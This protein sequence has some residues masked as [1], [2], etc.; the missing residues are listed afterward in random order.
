M[1]GPYRRFF[2]A[3]GTLRWQDFYHMGRPALRCRPTAVSGEL[4]CRPRRGG[5][6]L[7]PGCWQG[8]RLPRAGV[9]VLRT[10]AAFAR[11]FRCKE[12]PDLDWQHARLVLVQQRLASA[13]KLDVVVLLRRGATDLVA[14]IETRCSGVRQLDRGPAVDRRLLVALPRDSGKLSVRIERAPARCGQV[15]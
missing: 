15:P 10:P 5:V 1:D 9:Q 3:D 13:E 7:D 4:S 2:A 12:T 8:A 11:V 14:R 6:P